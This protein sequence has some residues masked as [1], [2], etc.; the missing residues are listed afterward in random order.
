MPD[1]SPGRRGTAGACRTLA[2][3]LPRRGN[4]SVA[5]FSRPYD[6]ARGKISTI[7]LLRPRSGGIIDR[8]T[9]PVGR[10][11]GLREQQVSCRTT[12]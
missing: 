10:L 3:A 11:S 5:A 8:G 12:K 7:A 4:I 6:R 2:T 1:R 9:E